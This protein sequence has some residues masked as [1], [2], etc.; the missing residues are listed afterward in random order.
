MNRFAITD[1]QRIETAVSF[2]VLCEMNRMPCALSVRCPPALYDH[3]CAR[4][5]R[6]TAYVFAPVLTSKRFFVAIIGPVGWPTG[7]VHDH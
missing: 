7:G 6:S 5:A 3:T 2:P 1:G 4:D